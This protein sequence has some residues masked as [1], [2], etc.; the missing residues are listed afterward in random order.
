MLNYKEFYIW[1]EGYLYGKLGNNHID[2]APIIEK[3]GEVKEDSNFFPHPK[4]TIP[5][6]PIEI[7]RPINPFDITFKNNT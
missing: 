2:I 7:P 1:L 3:M 6:N 4:T 5:I